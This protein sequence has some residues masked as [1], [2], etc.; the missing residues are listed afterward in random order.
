[1][2][3]SLSE[4][5]MWWLLACTPT[6]GDS[7]S[8]TETGDSAV[9]DG[10]HARPRT[11]DS[12][13][14]YV[15][16]PYNDDASQSDTWR[17]FRFDGE[18]VE[19]EEFELGRATQGR[20]AWT[21]DGEFV[22]LVDDTGGVH[23]P[24]GSTTEPYVS[25]VTVDPAGEV[26][27]LIDPN[28]AENGGGLYR[29]DIDCDTGALGEPEL[30]WATKNAAALALRPGTA[31]EAALIARE[32]A[33]V[34]GGV[35]LVDLE[36]LEVLAHIDAFGDDEAIVSDAAWDFE[37]ERLLVS[38]NSEFSGVATRIAV[39]AESGPIETLEIEDPV[40]LVTA[41]FANSSALA[42][43]GYGDAVYELVR[44]ADSYAVGEE[45]ASPALPGPAVVVERGALTGT[46]L[47]VENTGLW[48][49]EFS[50]GGGLEDGGRLVGWSGLAGIPGGIALQP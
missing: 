1:M 15:S 48:Q 7:S 18:L 6:P 26:A 35:H 16:F 5:L 12:H 11:G 47:V 30:I 28:W 10:C 29:A 43:S 24:A 32:L 50:E 2:L 33:G 36:S 44:T 42:V 14:L 13:E 39:I 49:L 3:L 8:V 31:S 22:F 9:F 17:R 27:W 41:P 37:G 38:D 34:A 19:E 20:G 45:V 40:S 25:S 4:A 21:P 46:V 23:G